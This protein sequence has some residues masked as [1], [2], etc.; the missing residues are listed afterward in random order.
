MSSQWIMAIFIVLAVSLAIAPIYWMRP[1]PRQRQLARLREYALSL[2]LRPELT[3][4]PEV[5]QRAGYEGRMMKYQLHR[6]SGDWPREGG[7]WL[8]LLQ[9]ADGPEQRF[10]WPDRGD[11]KGPDDLLR[12][13]Q[14][15]LPEGLFAIEA[16]P[17]GVG[18]YW[19]EAGDNA[20]VD[21]FFQLL[22]PWLTQYPE[23]FARSED[24]VLQ[25]DDSDGLQ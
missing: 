15:E 12:P 6:P 13:L 1:S 7:T 8:A 20:R 25:E 19:H 17:S 16:S 23:A 11:L 14:Q 21:R 2:G 3:T 5:M 4:V 10:V 18:F 24:D 9:P 22:Q